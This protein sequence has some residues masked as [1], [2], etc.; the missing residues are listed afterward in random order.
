MCPEAFCSGDVVTYKCNV[1]EALGTTQWTFPEG[2]CDSESIIR[3]TQEAGCSNVSGSCGPFVAANQPA[4]AAGE[5]LVSTLT[6]TASH[7]I[8]NSLI[9]CS[10]DPPGS[11]APVL[12]GSATLLVAGTHCMFLDV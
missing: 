4:N 1:S 2:H 8:S 6:V 5:C 3:L 11:P 10:N 7:N 9:Q 12:V